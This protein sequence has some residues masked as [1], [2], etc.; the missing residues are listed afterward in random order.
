MIRDELSLAELTR[1]IATENE[2]R[3]NAAGSQLDISEAEQKL[4]TLF[5]TNST[6]AVYGTLAPGRQNYHIVEP[7]GG[8]WTDGFI[9]GDLQ[10]T[11]WGATLGY[12]AFRPRAGGPILKICILKSPLLPSGWKHVDEFEGPEYIRILVPA[13]YA[14][15]EKLMAE[16]R[17]IYT[18][19]NL[20]AAKDW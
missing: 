16:E 12:P 2:R 17:R 6:L 15:D 8:D 4:D 13:F 9:E 10:Q 1:L 19:A 20:Y 5:G 14:E 7:L 18:V 11:G 3:K